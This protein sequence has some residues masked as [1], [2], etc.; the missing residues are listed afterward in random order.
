MSSLEA[1][2]VGVITLSATALVVWLLGSF[3]APATSRS[4]QSSSR[5]GRPSESRPPARIRAS[6]VSSGSPVRSTTS[7]SVRY[8]PRASSASRSPR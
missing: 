4:C 5:R 6:I 1:A 3:A 2:I 7:E 8:G